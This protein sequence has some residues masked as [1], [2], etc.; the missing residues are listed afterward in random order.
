MYLTTRSDCCVH[1]VAVKRRNNVDI[2]CFCF[3]CVHLVVVLC[4]YVAH[5]QKDTYENRN[6]LT[7]FTSVYECY[8]VF[9]QYLNRW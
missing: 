5:V 6:R 1:S 3:I 7:V 2:Y 8:V 9:E 4:S